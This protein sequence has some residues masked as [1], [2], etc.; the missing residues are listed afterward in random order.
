VETTL[1]LLADD[2]DFREAVEEV[3]Q[4]SELHRSSDFETLGLHDLFESPLDFAEVENVAA[5]RA[6]E[7]S[8][9]V[10]RSQRLID[11]LSALR[12]GDLVVSHSPESNSQSSACDCDL[13]AITLTPRVAIRSGSRPTHDAPGEAPR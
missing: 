9:R 1:V 7:M 2:S 4:L 3:R 13:K 11:L 12:A 6:G 10:K 5:V 8:V